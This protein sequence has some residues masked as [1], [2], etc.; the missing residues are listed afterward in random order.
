MRRIGNRT[1]RRLIGTS[2]S[3]RPS[4][5][6]YPGEPAAQMSLLDIDHYLPEDIL[7]KVDRTTMAVS[8]EGREPLLDHRLVEFA[9]SLP[10]HLRQGELGPKHLLKKILYR[11]VPRELV[12][13]PKQGFAIPL[14]N[15]LRT[16]LKELVHDYLGEER[17]RRAGIMDANLVSRAVKQFDAGDTTLGMPVWTLAGLR[18]VAGALGLG[19][20]QPASKL[21]NYTGNS[22][23]MSET[24][25]KRVFA[26]SVAVL[27]AGGFFLYGL[28]VERFGI[29]PSETIHSAWAA[30]KSLA[31][32][33]ELVPKGRLVKPPANGIA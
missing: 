30:A 24:F 19:Q 23:T 18:N 14:D 20:A 27:F 5:D 15:W 7:T 33:G 6:S 11:Y 16:D 9:L 13:R 17:I 32:H 25:A 22:F 26:L 3:L 8:I 1:N 4:A 2:G 10:Q 21:G 29:W 28:A 12:D 31:E